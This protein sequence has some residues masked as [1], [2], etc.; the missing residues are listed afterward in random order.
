MGWKK[1][2]HKFCFCCWL[3]PAFCRSLESHTD[4][5]S[6]KSF[7][8]HP[9]GPS[10][11]DQKKN[12]DPLLCSLDLIIYRF[13]GACLRRGRA[14]SFHELS[15]KAAEWILFSCP[16]F[17]GCVHFLEALSMVPPGFTATPQRAG[18]EWQEGNPEPGST[19]AQAAWP[20]SVTGITASQH[21]LPARSKHSLFKIFTP[22]MNFHIL[23]PLEAKGLVKL[24]QE[25][26]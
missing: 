26:P 15:A 23:V 7:L 18:N 2:E 16:V 24:P 10:P 20:R 1:R 6:R 5:L 13:T 4:L 22:Q 25:P 17:A 9:W 19:H 8:C 3:D 11:E 12:L 14:G 21:T